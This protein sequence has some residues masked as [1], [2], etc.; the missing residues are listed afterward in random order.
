MTRP[1]D[2]AKGDI[3][4]SY[5]DVSQWQ[6]YVPVTLPLAASHYDTFF[7]VRITVHL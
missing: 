1:T 6:F 3:Y 5:N 2:T 7:N 4:I